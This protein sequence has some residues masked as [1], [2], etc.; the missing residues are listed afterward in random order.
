MSD[1]WR[2]QKQDSQA[3]RRFLLE[4]P[5]AAANRFSRITSH[6]TRLFSPWVRD[7]RRH[8]KPPSGPLPPPASRCFPVRH[9]SPLFTIVHHCSPLFAIVRHCSPL[10]AIVRHCSA[11]KL[12]GASL[13]VS[14]RVEAKCVRAPS[15]RC[16]P[17]RCGAA[18]RGYGAAWAAAAPRAGNTA[19]DVKTHN[20]R[21]G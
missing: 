20:P 4:Q 13:H 14:P 10:F 11:K 17:A 7:A 21:H 12:F 6:E 1:P 5:Q 18:W 16:F 2:K 19:S 8:R 15:G 3:R 9:C